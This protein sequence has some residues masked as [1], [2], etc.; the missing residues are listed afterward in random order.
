MPRLLLAALI[1]LVGCPDYEADAD[2]DGLRICEGDCDDA[3]AWSYPGA[4]EL[5]DCLDN[6]CDW[7]VDEGLDSVDDDGDGACEGVDLGGEVVECCSGL[8]VA[9]DCDDDDH[10]VYPQDL[11]GDGRST[12][13]LDCDDDDPLTFYVAQEACD[14]L[15]NDCDGFV[16]DDESDA[17]GDGL[18]AC[19]GDCDDTD[20]AVNPYAVELCDGIDNDCDPTTDESVDGDGDGYVRCSGDCDDADGG[21]NAGS[22]DLDG[23]GYP[24]WW[25]PG[26]YDY[27]TYPA[28]GWDCDD[29]DP[30]VY[31][32]SGC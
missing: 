26:P 3:D 27:A 11:D 17:D 10:A 15:D 21:P 5:T 7:D 30:D 13:D 18:M 19:E 4:T 29:S 32:G 22:W 12:C 20:A 23:D 14:G 6:D 24:E 25:Q 28:L 9:G 1:G 16:P 2:F 8:E 31:P